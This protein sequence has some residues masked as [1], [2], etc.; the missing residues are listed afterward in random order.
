LVER[1]LE[2]AGFKEVSQGLG[3]ERLA[4]MIKPHAAKEAAFGRMFLTLDFQSVS[5]VDAE[6]FEVPC[7]MVG[8]CP[9]HRHPVLY[10]GT[11][12]EEVFGVVIPWHGLRVPSDDDV[13]IETVAVLRGTTPSDPAPYA[14]CRITGM[15]SQSNLSMASISDTKLLSLSKGTACV[16][17]FGSM[18]VVAG[19]EMPGRL[20][21]DPDEA[22]GAVFQVQRPYVFALW[23]TGIDELNIPLCAMLVP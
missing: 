6:T 14:A 2:S 9:S 8:S 23:H 7:M 1:L 22:G 11:S 12:E 3:L 10:L 15:R 16:A 13:F 18:T 19:R 5:V 20:R 17:E 21:R 4:E